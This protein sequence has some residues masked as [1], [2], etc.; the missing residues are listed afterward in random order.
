MPN[1][2]QRPILAQRSR[3]VYAAGMPD[4]SNTP[5]RPAD[6]SKL[7]GF[8]MDAATEGEPEERIPVIPLPSPWGRKGG[9][10]ADVLVLRS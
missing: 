9:L 4:R 7:A 3:R 5:K 1:V 10:R 2:T 8:I 6:S